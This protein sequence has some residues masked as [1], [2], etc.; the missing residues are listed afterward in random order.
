MTFPITIF[1]S[2]Y[3]RQKGKSWGSRRIALMTLGFTGVLLSLFA[4]AAMFLTARSG[5]YDP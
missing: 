3:P 2:R 5:G 1:E 4:S